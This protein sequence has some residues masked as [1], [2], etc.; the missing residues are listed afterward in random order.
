MLAQHILDHM[1]KLGAPGMV[2]WDALGIAS[3]LIDMN[4]EGSIAFDAAKLAAELEP[5]E[6]PAQDSDEW[7]SQLT[8][9]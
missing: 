3:Q 9:V 8:E 7:P 5:S 1:D 2:Q 4:K 6:P